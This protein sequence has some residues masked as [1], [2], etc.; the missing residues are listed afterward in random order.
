ME[1]ENGFHF[2]FYF[3]N[4][5]RFG[6]VL[7]NNLSKEELDEYTNLCSKTYDWN[8]FIEEGKTKKVI[9]TFYNWIKENNLLSFNIE[10]DNLIYLCEAFTPPQFY[11]NK[12]V[13]N[14]SEPVLKKLKTKKLI[15]IFNWFSEPLY[16]EAFNTNIEKICLNNG[17]NVL[18]F[19]V[20]T[21]AN[22][23]KH[24]NIKHISDHFFIKNSADSLK[25]FLQSKIFKPN[26]FDYVCEIVG[27]DIF[28][29]KNKTKHFLSLNRHVD[30]P[31]RY[32]LG[33]F[34]EKNN[35]WDK[36]HF[37]F[38]VCD[39]QKK[40]DEVQEAIP[41]N[42]LKDLEIYN[43]NFYKKIPMEIDTTF[44]NSGFQIGSFGTSNIYYK[45]IYEDSV[46]NII[47]ETTFTSNKVF[48][49]E[50]TFHPIINLQPF[51]FFASNGQLQELRNLGFK[52]FGHVI[53][54]SYDEEMDSKKRFKMVCDEL[55]R[56]SKLNLE[57]L[58]ELYLSCKDICIHNR[59]HLLTFLK[60]DVF[61]NS[62]EKIKE[63]KWSLQEKKL[64]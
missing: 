57:E 35:L 51:I 2:K 12:F 50:K 18:D 27:Y 31:H 19:F 4:I 10:D 21:S 58:N 46:I 20:F 13:E 56:L 45:K 63:I 26:S 30:R 28:Q 49:S 17:F 62:L 53:D 43:D 64:L 9:N 29:S 59:K 33:I 16:D 22:N 60:Y 11:Q 32:G 1:A 41:A 61:K 14:L 8:K 7:P 37:S 3:E 24:C 15:V 52:T 6:R 42:E 36:G 25:T 34:I 38:L 54:E 55:L 5:D 47:T 23:V 44:L 40:G 48:L 39:K